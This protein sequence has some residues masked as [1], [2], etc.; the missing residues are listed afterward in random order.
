[1]REE[2]AQI[3]KDRAVGAD[4]QK[5]LNTEVLA[6]C[7]PAPAPDPDQSA[8]GGQ[9]MWLPIQNNGWNCYANA[10]FQSVFSLPGM[11]ET[12]MSLSVTSDVASQVEEVASLQN[13]LSQPRDRKIDSAPA[14]QWILEEASRLNRTSRGQPDDP[15]SFFGSQ[16]DPRD[17]LTYL[18]NT[19]PPE[20]SQSFELKTAD[21]KQCQGCGSRTEGEE[22]SGHVLTWTMSQEEMVWREVMKENLESPITFN[23][24]CISCGGKGLPHLKESHLVET[25]QFLV[26]TLPVNL[27]TPERGMHRMVGRKIKG[28][29][30]QLTEIPTS[31]GVDR[32]RLCAT[33]LHQGETNMA[34]HYISVI[35]N[36]NQ[37][38]GWWVLDDLHPLN[39]VTKPTFIQNLSFQYQD[40]KRPSSRFH[41][42]ILL[43]EK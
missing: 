1:M 13:L 34:G 26:I 9:R 7:Q 14:I 42:Y 32:F 23:A 24:D 35:R 19:L 36:R 21:S 22:H 37:G 43:F 31:K 15:L 6:Q 39:A 20:V 5:M 27:M 40:D 17:F 12:L 3:R 8:I 28:F 29:N 38:K 41:A 33:I 30:A 25:G 2:R 18:L 16:Q 10:T 11:A 4:A